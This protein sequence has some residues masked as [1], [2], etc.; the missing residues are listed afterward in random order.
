MPLPPFSVDD[1]KNISN[2][3]SLSQEQF[4]VSTNRPQ[5]ATRFTLYEYYPHTSNVPF[6]VPH[7][8]PTAHPASP[9][10]PMF[11]DLPL[12]ESP[13]FATRLISTLPR[14]ASEPMFKIPDDQHYAPEPNSRLNDPYFY[15]QQRL[16]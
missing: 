15:N 13:T 16:L 14:S 9:T 2:Y 1:L 12:L 8:R 3:S 5:H 7:Q 10:A 6:T 4:F 11:L